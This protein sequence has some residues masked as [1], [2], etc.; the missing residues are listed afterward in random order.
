MPYQCW[1]THKSP[2]KYDHYMGANQTD[3]DHWNCYEDNYENHW[4]GANCSLYSL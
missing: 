2:N 4:W 1:R 3:K